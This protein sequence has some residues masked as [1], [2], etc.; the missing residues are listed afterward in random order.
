MIKYNLTRA[1]LPNLITKLKE[2]DFSKIWKVQVT[3]RKHIRNLSQNDYYWAILE[4]LSDHLGY[5]KEEIHELL[6]YKFL[7]YAKEIAGQ[8]VVIV[9]STT[10]LDTAQFSDYIENVLKFAN[11][12]GCS[13]QD[14]LP[15]Y[16]TH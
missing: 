16:E 10:D 8:P 6:K 1:N 13:F 11:E 2:L 12:Y 5:T 14:G 7:K 3:E 4:G 15:Q 9:P